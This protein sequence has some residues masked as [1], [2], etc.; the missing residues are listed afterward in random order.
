MKAKVILW[1]LDGKGRGWLVNEAELTNIELLDYIE[2]DKSVSL[3]DTT[4]VDYLLISANRIAQNVVEQLASKGLWPQKVILLGSSYS[5]A[6]HEDVALF[7]MRE[8]DTVT[9]RH[10]K[11]LMEAKHH[12]NVTSILHQYD[13]FLI[14]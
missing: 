9:Y 3:S 12:D 6:E 5:W 10:T 8:S 14:A 11:Y 1:D 2:K 4:H 13:I 7:L